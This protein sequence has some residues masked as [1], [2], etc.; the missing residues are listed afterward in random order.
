MI[1]LIDKEVRHDIAQILDAW[2]V[3]MA[4]LILSVKLFLANTVSLFGFKEFTDGTMGIVSWFIAVFT[5]IWA[6]FRA[7]ESAYT[8]YIKL[9]DWLAER[10]RKKAENENIS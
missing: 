3:T 1:E 2:T 8:N 5:M 10:K 7:F 9:R 6:F 4:S